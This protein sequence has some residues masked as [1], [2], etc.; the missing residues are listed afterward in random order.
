MELRSLIR[1]IRREVNRSRSLV[2]TES[3]WKLPELEP[4]R[5]DTDKLE[6]LSTKAGVE[7]LVE[8]ETNT[9]HFYL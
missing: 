5:H 2:L 6:F 4:I 3:E 7:W 8:Y 1:K 9:A